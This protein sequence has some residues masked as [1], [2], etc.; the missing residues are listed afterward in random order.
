M[1]LLSLVVCSEAVVCQHMAL[2]AATCFHLFSSSSCILFFSSLSGLQITNSDTYPPLAQLS[3]IKPCIVSE[4]DSAQDQIGSFV[5]WQ[6]AKAALLS[7][8]IQVPI[9]AQRKLS[10]GRTHTDYTHFLH[11]RRNSG[12]VYREKHRKV[13]C[14]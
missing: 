3:V 4:R 6:E 1:L 14:P 7:S 11:C 13:C 10:V 8:A 12:L 9:L 2:C 5:S